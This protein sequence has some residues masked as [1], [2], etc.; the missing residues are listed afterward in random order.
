MGK[1]DVSVSAQ[2]FKKASKTDI[3]VNVADQLAINFGLQIG[4]VSETVEVTGAN[5]TVNTETADVSQTISTKQMT[6]LAINGGEFTSL[7]QLLPGASRTMGDEGGTGFNSSRGFA[8]NGQREV[9]TGFQVDGVENTDMGNG[10]GLLTSPGMETI[11]EFKMN[12]S[13]YSA[14]YGNAGGAN[15]LIVT[16]TGTR[17]FHGAAYDCFRNDALDARYFL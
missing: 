16:R 8:I 17:D 13:N 1:Y 3:Q 7:Q 14:E 10:T 4:N 9:S 15:L 5:P 2:G 12:T 11:G 6:D